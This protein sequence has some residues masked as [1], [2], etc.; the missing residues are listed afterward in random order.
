MF[1]AFFAR[2]SHRKSGKLGR[3]GGVAVTVANE[4]ATRYVLQTRML[5]PSRHVF[6]GATGLVGSATVL[7]ILATD[8]VARVLGLVRPGNEGAR[9]RFVATLERAARLYGLGDSLDQAIHSRCE[10]L[11][12]DVHELR[13]GVDVVPAE[14]SG[15]E[16]WHCAA[17]LQFHDRFRAKVMRTNVDGTANVLGLAKELG[18]GVL[19]FVSTAYVAGTRT[20]LIREE[21]VL[22]NDG[23]STNNHYERSKVIAERMVRESGVPARILRPSIVIGHSRTYGTLNFNGLYGFMRGVWKF[24]RMMARTQADL[25]NTLE[26]RL[27]ADPDGQLDLIPVDFVARDAVSLSRAGADPGVYHL[28]SVARCPTQRTLGL[29][30]EALGLRWPTFVSDREE[31]TW[32]DRKLDAGIRVYNAYVV[33]Y[34]HFDRSATDRWLERPAGADYVL[35]DEKLLGFYQWYIDQD[36]AHRTRKVT[37]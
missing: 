14:W 5:S 3:F 22:D 26:V 10:A 21:P 25:M 18:V 23:F 8:P 34:K 20:G 32:I 9:P 17:A 30:F 12:A 28:A 37:E 24:R 1:A 19:N 16:M 2:P 29:I 33:G 36:L 4:Q 13:C 35:S 6:T 15:A 7:E 31:L 11:A 27:V